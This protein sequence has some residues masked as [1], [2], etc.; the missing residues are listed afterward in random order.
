MLH[1]HIFLGKP[2]VTDIAVCEHAPV[3]IYY[4]VAV[5][6]KLFNVVLNNGIVQHIV[7]H[8]RGDKLFARAGHNRSRE[9]IIGDAAGYLSDDVCRSRRDKH[10]VRRLCKRN[11]LN[12]VLE[13]AVKRVDKTLVLRERLKG[14]GIYKLRGVLRHKHMN[15]S[16][17]LFE[18]IRDVSHLVCRNRACYRK[19]DCFS[20]KHCEIPPN[21]R[22]FFVLV[23]IIT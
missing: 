14:Y 20:V 4:A 10:D 15:V 22:D 1:Q 7:V 13:I 17:E 19:N 21:H 2:P 5:C 11:M 6:R 23:Y 9:H 8:R 18:H 16:T 3:R 12:A